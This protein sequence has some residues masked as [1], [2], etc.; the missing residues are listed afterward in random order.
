MNY[1]VT[2]A[3]NGLTGKNSFFDASIFV[4]AE[5]VPWIIGFFFCLLLFFSYVKNFKVFL[6][7]FT[8]LFAASL[9]S[10]ALKILLK[11]QR[12]FE[13]YETINPVFI[14]YGFGSFPSSHAFFF[15]TL[16]TLSF[17]FLRRFFLFFL[18]LSI[19]I[20]LSRVFAG[21]HF[22]YDILAG[23]I[24]GFIFTYCIVYLYEKSM[25]KQV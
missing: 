13:I 11:F 24:S 8:V 4:Y 12:P 17:F 10:A 23:W 7:S 19:V 21:V 5:I 2:H 18:I 15:A 16:T 9:A 3:F 1:I 14:T 20:S 25:G 22:L 6:F